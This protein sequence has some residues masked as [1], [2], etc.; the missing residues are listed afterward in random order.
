[1]ENSISGIIEQIKKEGVE[2]AEQQAADIISSAEQKAA[3]IEDNA[4]NEAEEILE[5]ARK[6]SE[7]LKTNAETSIRQASR[8]V[9]LGLRRAIVDLFDRVMKKETGK[10]IDDE[11][12]GKMIKILAE[13]FS[14]GKENNVEI[15]LGEED[16][17][18]LEK[19]M[20]GLLGAE[21]AAGVT[22][23]PSAEVAKGFRVGKKDSGVYYDFTDEAISEALNLYLNK[24]LL[25]ILSGDR[26]EDE[27]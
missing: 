5:K 26:S 6:E 23:T 2:K 15:I 10:A 12:I 17:Q 16:K 9:L 21:M 18:K 20:V 7:K 8:D 25:E 27:K 19:N 24:K 3:E 1:M 13:K 22:L 11:V 4:R 14:P